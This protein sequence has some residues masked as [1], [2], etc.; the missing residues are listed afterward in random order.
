MK[1]TASGW[2]RFVYT[3]ELAEHTITDISDIHANWDKPG[4]TVGPEW[5]ALQY[6]VSIPRG[7]SMGGDYLFTQT[8]GNAEVLALAATILES[9][10]LGAIIESVRSSNRHGH[11]QQAAAWV[12]A[13]SDHVREQRTKA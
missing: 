1:L 5:L 8:F 11:R 3:R 6:R 12:H 2:R 13:F 4:I 10:P 7:T 9:M